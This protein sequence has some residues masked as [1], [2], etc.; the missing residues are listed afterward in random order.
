MWYKEPAI[1]TDWSYDW[2]G[3]AQNYWDS[4][5]HSFLWDSISS[6]CLFTF[7]LGNLKQLANLSSCNVRMLLKFSL[8]GSATYVARPD[9]SWESGTQQV[10][11]NPNTFY[12]VSGKSLLENTNNKTKKFEVDVTSIIQKAIKQTHPNDYLFLDKILDVK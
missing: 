7:T 2:S 6:K 10:T 5:S 1:L 3:V 4:S 9:T 12:Y 11:F 8:S